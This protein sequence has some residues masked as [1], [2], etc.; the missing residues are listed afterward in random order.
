M[1][2]SRRRLLHDA[3]TSAPVLPSILL[4][5]IASRGTAAVR[6]Q[7]YWYPGHALTMK[8]TG[9]DTGGT[10]TWMLIENSPREGVPFHNTFTKT[11]L[12]TYWTVCSRSPSG[13]APSRA[14]QAPTYTVPD[15]FR[16]G[17]R[18]SGVRGDAFS[19][20]THQLVSK[21]I[22]SPSLSLSSPRP[23][24]RPSICRSFNHKRRPHERS[25]ELFAPAR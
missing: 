20:C 7:W 15:K 17:G 9:K 14:Q 16:T 21:D 22:S 8:S 18:T 24:S 11:S 3:L 25:S 23:N 19:V 6:E 10:T 2:R 12:F 13:I 5:S 1:N 4:A